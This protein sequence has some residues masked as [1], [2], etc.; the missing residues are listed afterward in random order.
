MTAGAVILSKK[1][2]VG[3]SSARPCIFTL[4]KLPRADI[5]SAPTVTGWRM[6]YGIRRGAFYMLPQA[7]SA[8]PCSFTLRKLPRADIE[9]APTVTGWRMPYGIRRGAFYMLPQASS[10]R[11]CSF[12]LRKLPRA[13]IESAPTVTGWRMPYGIRR[14]AFYMLPQASADRREKPPSARQTPPIR[15]RWRLRQRGSGAPKGRR[16]R[17]LP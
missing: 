14:G 4:R 15:G 6:P 3:A 8:R 7:S 17:T 13:D 16:E 11:P 2:F 10:A 12:T 9:S 1:C 5:E